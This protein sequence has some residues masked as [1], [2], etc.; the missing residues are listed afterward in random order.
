MR[1]RSIVLTRE[2]EAA[3][4]SITIE[5]GCIWLDVR[6]HDSFLHGV[7]VLVTRTDCVDLVALLTD[8]LKI[9]TR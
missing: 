1:P 7:E 4:V 3:R 8:A 9:A 6:T 5:E 2:L